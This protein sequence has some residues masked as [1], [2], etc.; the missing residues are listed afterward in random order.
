MDYKEILQ[1]LKAQ[2]DKEVADLKVVLDRKFAIVQGALEEKRKRILLAL[3][4]ELKVDIERSNNEAYEMYE[5]RMER[6]SDAPEI[7][8]KHNAE[9]AK[10]ALEMILRSN[11][12]RLENF[13]KNDL[14]V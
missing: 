2:G 7:M 4:E 1:N 13:K 8:K 3:Y 5:R 12:T 9:S 14:G 11:K 6:V 10:T